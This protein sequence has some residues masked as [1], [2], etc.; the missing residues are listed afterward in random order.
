MTR[1]IV[2]EARCKFTESSSTCKEAITNLEP[3]FLGKF[4]IGKG[5]KQFIKKFGP[6]LWM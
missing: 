1:K 3:S 6:D 2:L 5:A 4:V